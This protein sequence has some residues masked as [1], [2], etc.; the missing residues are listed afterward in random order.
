M[1][2]PYNIY[3]GYDS[4]EDNAYRVCV[5][6]I[7]Q[8]ASEPS[9]ISIKPLNLKELR[10]ANLY[11]RPDDPLSST[12]FTFSRFLVPLLEN[13]RGVALFCDCDFLFVDDVIELFDLY[14]HSKALQCCMHDY[15]PKSQYKMQG[16]VQHLYPRKNWSSLILYNCAHPSNK[17]L[18]KELVNSQTGQYLHRFNWLEDREIGQIP[19]EWNWLV[20]WYK[21]PKDGIPKAIHFT[22]GGPWHNNYE[23]CEYSNIWR[24]YLANS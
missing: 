15:T 7:L 24:Q 19:H 5:N 18:T 3:I 13:Y 12:E 2:Y 10:Q 1:S 22:E 8:N 4:R 21:E 23:N 6:S 14:D 9:L 16:A 17:K 20:G 11:Y